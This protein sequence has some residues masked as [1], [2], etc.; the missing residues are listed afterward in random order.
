MID[1]K[2][3]LKKLD[4]LDKTLLPNQPKISIPILR[5]IY[6]KMQYGI[7]FNAI[8]VH[9]DKTIIDGHHRYISSVIAGLELER[10]PSQKPSFQNRDG[11]NVIEWKNVEFA[12]VDWDKPE[13]IEI[14]NIVD[15]K[16]NNV[17]LEEVKRII[18]QK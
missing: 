12:D 3:F 7:K 2:M 1:K 8:K 13:E 17:S 10:V 6:L 9:S 14:L 5:R 18:E 16:Y 11:V 4:G 15:A